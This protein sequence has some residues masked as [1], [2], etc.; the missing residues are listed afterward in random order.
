MA[1]RL[2]Q[3]ELQQMFGYEARPPF[4]TRCLAALR[5]VLAAIAF[6]I[7]VYAFSVFWLLGE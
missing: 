3:R 5:V 4:W 7:I 2:T 6:S 1:R